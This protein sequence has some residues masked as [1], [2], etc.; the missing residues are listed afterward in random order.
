MVINAPKYDRVLSPGDWISLEVCGL[1]PQLQQS[2]RPEQTGSHLL[3]D[4]Q[5]LSRF[6]RRT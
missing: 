1:K 5:H 6:V 2:F 3:I 4:L